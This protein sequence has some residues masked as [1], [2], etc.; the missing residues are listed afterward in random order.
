MA[1]L[2]IAALFQFWQES[3]QRRKT[4]VVTVGPVTVSYDPEL[5]AIARTL[6][7]EGAAALPVLA[8]L[9]GRSL[10]ADASFVVN[11]YADPAEFRTKLGRPPDDSEGGGFSSPNGQ[12]YVY[13][14]LRHGPVGGRDLPVPFL[15]RQDFTHELT[16]QVTYR[17]Y[18]AAKAMAWPLWLGEG[19]SELGSHTV[20]ARRSRDDERT[21]EEYELSRWQE[22][23]RQ[24]AVPATGRALLESKKNGALAGTYTGAYFLFRHLQRQGGFPRFL[25]LLADGRE[26]AGALEEV[27]GDVD[28]AWAQVRAR[29]DAA[30]P[31]PRWEGVSVEQIGDS[32]R[33]V[34]RPQKDGFIV[35]M[36][37]ELRAAPA[38]Q[39][40][41]AL[42]PVGGRELDVYPYYNERLRDDY[43]KVA[44]L[45][46][47]IQIYRLSPGGSEKLLAEAR[48]KGP[49]AIGE[50]ETLVWH[51]LQ[52]SW[53]RTLVVT[54]DGEPTRFDI[55][56][57][58]TGKPFRVAVGTYDGVAHVKDLQV[59][60][61]PSP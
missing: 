28:A 41:F 42:Q 38:I 37:R 34:S 59:R 35:L 53:Q 24:G 21:F 13:W 9:F 4:P 43:L 29:L 39:A 7:S 15:H 22:A 58:A 57:P 52:V 16:H 46:T 44:I 32:Y 50:D 3:E 6:A 60:P 1:A 48:C 51:N 12:A 25:G 11:A 27:L 54:I 40:S 33:L 8:A 23:V 56:P 26:P 55:P 36:D 14:W 5:K 20:L 18:P 19:L 17:L 30:A 31:A 45:R 2:I 49:L 47:A 61:A 10:P